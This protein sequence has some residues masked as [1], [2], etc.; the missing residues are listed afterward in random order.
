M[1]DSANVRVAVSGKVSIGPTATA[2][3]TTAE[4]TLNV[5]FKDLGYVSEDG[6]TESRERS[7]EQIKAWQ[8]GDIVRETITDSALRFQFTLIESN[9][10]TIALFYGATVDTDDGSLVIV[11]SATG[12]RK[13][14]VLDVIDGDVLIRYYVPQGEILEVG[15]VVYSNGAPIG[16]DVTLSTYPD[17]GIGG[18]A[19]RWQTDLV[20]AP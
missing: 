6:V 11:P 13:A 5:A 19:K 1:S 15:D 9:P 20:V 8:D 17:S 16:Y 10:E 3:P 7:T 4:S 2:A 14:F 12:G 18:N